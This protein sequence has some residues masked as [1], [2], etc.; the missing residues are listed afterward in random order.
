MI[1]VCLAVAQFMIVGVPAALL[2][3][4]RISPRRIT[5]YAFLLGAGI[6]SLLLLLHALLGLTW[7]RSSVTIAWL[8]LAAGLWVAALRREPA[9]RAEPAS[10]TPAARVAAIGV[11][12]VSLTLV[13]AHGVFATAA[14]VGTWDFWAIWGL[15]ARLFFVHGSIDWAFLEQPL[16]AFAHPDYPLLLPLDYVL[17]ALHAGAWSDRWLGI[18]T[19]LFGAAILLIVRDLFEEELPAPIAAVATLAVASV[20]LTQ[21]IGMAEAPMIAFGTAA[22]LTLRRGDDFLGAVLLGF[23]ASTKNEGLTLIVAAA[24]AMLLV[25]RPGV[26]RLWPAVLISA[27]WLILRALHSL[28]T[29]LASGPVAERALNNLARASEVVQVFG[30]TIPDRPLFWIALMI[31][32]I[33]FMKSWRA[34]SFLLA[35]VLFQVSFFLLVYLITPYGIRWHI[36]NSWLRLLDQVAI[37]LAFVGLVASGKSL[38]RVEESG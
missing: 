10:S 25:R 24:M 15:K 30:Q 35:A 8:L 1:A 34:E 13:V 19:T 7:S 5:G 4:G 16:N 38:M 23:G 11:D 36:A 2:L 31:A 17:V 6:C 18:L 37:P 9:K 33:L 32:A 26:L 12:A 27:P 14:P 28:P 21:W 29:R 22:L 3:S 20:A